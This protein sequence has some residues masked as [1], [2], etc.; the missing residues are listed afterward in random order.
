M[1]MSTIPFNLPV[2]FSFG[3]NGKNRKTGFVKSVSSLQIKAKAQNTFP[4]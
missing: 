1:Q 2:T 3:L 4:N